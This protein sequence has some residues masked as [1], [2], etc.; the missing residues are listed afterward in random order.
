MVAKKAPLTDDDDDDD[1]DDGDGNQPGWDDIT[2]SAKEMGSPQQ[3][4]R[5]LLLLC[6]TS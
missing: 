1:D 3:E 2:A 5:G 4:N 6:K